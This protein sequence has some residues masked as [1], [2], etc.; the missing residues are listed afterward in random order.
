[1]HFAAKRSGKVV[2]SAK[3]CVARQAGLQMW[4]TAAPL[5]LLPLLCLY[6]LTVSYSCTLLEPHAS[7]LH[8]SKCHSAASQLE[9]AVFFIPSDLKPLP[10]LRQWRMAIMPRG[11]LYQLSN[12]EKTIMDADVEHHN[13]KRTLQ[14]HHTSRV[15]TCP[16][17]ARLVHRTRC[18]WQL[19]CPLSIVP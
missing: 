17:V 1:M 7:S 13:V 8:P 10:F 2:R 6:Y 12:W 9:N 4:A 19:I 15:R 14:L 16:R 3:R 11:H 5:Q 18:F